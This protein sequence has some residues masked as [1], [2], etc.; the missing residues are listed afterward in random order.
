L[1]LAKTFWRYKLWFGLFFGERDRNG[2]RSG[3]GLG[4]LGGWSMGK[5]RSGAGLGSLGDGSPAE[6]RERGSRDDDAPLAA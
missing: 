6:E 3:A 1:L 4:N 2:D 5:A